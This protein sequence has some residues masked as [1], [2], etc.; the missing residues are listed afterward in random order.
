MLATLWV[1]RPVR[2]ILPHR[3]APRGLSMDIML[4][5]P[6]MARPV[7]TMGSPPRALKQRR[8][9]MDGPS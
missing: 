9:A 4:D 7:R 6:L 5:I 2:I 3:K 8:K 1:V